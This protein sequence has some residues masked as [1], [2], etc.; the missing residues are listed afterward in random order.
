MECVM[1]LLIMQGDDG[2]GMRR[3]VPITPHSGRL[4]KTLEHTRAAFKLSDSG[5]ICLTND[6]QR[7]MHGE[8]VISSALCSRTKPLSPL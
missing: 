5:R 8:E 4:S 3:C 1:L 7:I 6:S 2:M